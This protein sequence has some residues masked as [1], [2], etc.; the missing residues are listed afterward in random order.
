MRAAISTSKHCIA[1]VTA[2]L[3]FEYFNVSHESVTL[4]LEGMTKRPFKSI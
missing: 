2:T 1:Q 4:E 3:F